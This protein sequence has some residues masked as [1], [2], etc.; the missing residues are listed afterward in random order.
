M[1]DRFD[2]KYR[3]RDHLTL[4]EIF[5]CR[6]FQL[7]KSSIYVSMSLS[8]WK[9]DCSSKKRTVSECNNTELKIMLQGINE[10]NRFLWVNK[11]Y[12]IYLGIHN[13][14]V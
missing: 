1:M 3:T 13:V 9:I 5:N 8:K 4:R 12:L 11:I 2:T 10:K 6:N 7:Y 14:V